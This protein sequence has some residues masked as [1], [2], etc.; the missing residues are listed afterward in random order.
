VVF[1]DE[2]PVEQQ[3]PFGEFMCGQTQPMIDPNR[4][5]P[6]SWDYENFLRYK[7][8]KYIPVYAWD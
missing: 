5:S 7:E 3:K 8:A 2:L 1:I 4:S 6:Y